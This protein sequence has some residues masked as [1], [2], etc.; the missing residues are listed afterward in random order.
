MNPEDRRLKE[1]RKSLKRIWKSKH[2][3][4]DNCRR[5]ISKLNLFRIHKAF[6]FFFFFLNKILM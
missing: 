3:N 1:I 4:L 5:V 2:I 6:F